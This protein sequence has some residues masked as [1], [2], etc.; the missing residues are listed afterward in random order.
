MESSIVEIHHFQEHVA[1]IGCGTVRWPHPLLA[2]QL[3]LLSAVETAP[4]ARFLVLRL[5]RHAC[6]I[7][8]APVLRSIL[9]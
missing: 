6:P 5:L 8:I 7:A 4:F 9:G 2:F 1:P 3:I